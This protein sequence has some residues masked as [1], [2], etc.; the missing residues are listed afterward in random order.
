MCVSE[1]LP[2]WLAELTLIALHPH[3]PCPFCIFVSNFHNAL[4]ARHPNKFL[5]VNR[6]NWALQMVFKLTTLY[7]GTVT[8]PWQIS[9]LKNTKLH[10]FVPKCLKMLFHAKLSIFA[11]AKKVLNI[12]F[13][14]FKQ[15]KAIYHIYHFFKKN[16]VLIEVLQRSREREQSSQIAYITRVGSTW[17]LPYFFIFYFYFFWK[18]IYLVFLL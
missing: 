11:T 2:Q 14:S 17:A 3:I 16:V 15:I 6:M 13:K 7:P 5:R 12:F 9:G 8:W 4:L 18:A 1:N 10:H